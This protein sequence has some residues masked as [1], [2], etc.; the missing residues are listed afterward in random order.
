VAVCALPF[1]EMES[2]APVVTQSVQGTISYV[3]RSAL[4]ALPI[5]IEPNPTEY[6]ASDDS[7]GREEVQVMTQNVFDPIPG[8]YLFYGG[9]CLLAFL[10]LGL[11][12]AFILRLHLRSRPNGDR[13]YRLLH[14]SAKS[15]QAFTFGHL[16]Y[17]SIDVPD[18]GDFDHIL[19]H[20]RVHARQL[21]TFDILVCEVFLCL[22]WFHPAAWWLR[23]K[24]R[25]NLEYLVDQEVVKR[26]SDRRSYQL[27][28]VR[29]SQAAQGLALALPFSEPSLKSRIVRLSGMP[30]YRLVG[31][32]AALGLLLWMDGR[33]DGDVER[34]DG[35]AG[36]R[37]LRRIPRG[38]C[39][40]RR[41][42][43]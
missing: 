14:P 18:D 22:F 39:H 17:F 24:M 26:G 1:L 32:A 29:Q 12:L 9:V 34:D 37:Q 6:L 41:S 3:E 27:A 10:L 38:I 11:R 19:A 33:G 40:A 5:S 21:H 8:P 4:S 28:L 20:E 2:P 31:V 16:L 42:L 15:G 23:T 7:F 13:S 43:L 36:Q 30:E 25:A 35:R